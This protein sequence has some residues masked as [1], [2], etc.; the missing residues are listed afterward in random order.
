VPFKG[1]QKAHSFCVG[2]QQQTRPPDSE[3]SPFCMHAGPNSVR[4]QQPRGQQ[5]VQ[6]ATRRELTAVLPATWL[7]W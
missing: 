6:A 2:V 5:L 3:L 1:E 7:A 4:T